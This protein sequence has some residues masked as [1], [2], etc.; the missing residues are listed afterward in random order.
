MTE[1]EA[2]A[3]QIQSQVAS[4]ARGGVYPAVGID[5]DNYVTPG[6]QSLGEIGVAFVARHNHE[7]RRTCAGERVLDV[8]IEPPGAGPLK[9][10]TRGVIAVEEDQ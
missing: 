2:S 7:T 6:S 1:N 9:A 4:D 5:R 8:D 3:A 10:A